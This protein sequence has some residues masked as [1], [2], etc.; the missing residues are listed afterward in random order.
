MIRVMEGRDWAQT[1]DGL[2]FFIKGDVLWRFG[3]LQEATPKRSG[4]NVYSAMLR[5]AEGFHRLL[6]STL[7]KGDDNAVLNRLP[8][9]EIDLNADFTTT[10][11]LWCVDP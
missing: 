3:C 5:R 4:L 2:E 9:S 1:E 6:R 10:A 11:G 8:N 7:L